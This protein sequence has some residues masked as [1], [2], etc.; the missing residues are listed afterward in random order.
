MKKFAASGCGGSIRSAPRPALPDPARRT[1][2]TRCRLGRGMVSVQ[3]RREQRGA[4]HLLTGDALG[5]DPRVSH[6]SASVG[7]R[8]L[9]GADRDRVLIAKEWSTEFGD[10]RPLVGD[11]AL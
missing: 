2:R 5:T 8:A 3:G 9:A 4:T 7:T 1:R 6:G 10:V 11:G